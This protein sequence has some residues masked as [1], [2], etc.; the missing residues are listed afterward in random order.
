M[1]PSS[2][3]GHA[4]AGSRRVGHSLVTSSVPISHARG[5][6]APSHADSGGWVAAADG[7][8]WLD[9]G[10]LEGAFSVQLPVRSPAA[11]GGAATPCSPRW[12]STGPLAGGPRKRRLSGDASRRRRTHG[13]SVV[14]GRAA[15]RHQSDRPSAQWFSSPS[16]P[17]SQWSPYRSMTCP[18]VAP[19]GR[20]CKSSTI[21]PPL[22]EPGEP[23]AQDGG[24][25]VPSRESIIP[26]F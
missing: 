11:G 4:P 2:P 15:C 1:A 6:G 22:G 20:V 7:R 23:G 12:I 10:R 26:R 25:D 5:L 21:R 18:S 24:V 13:Q 16:N 9:P 17:I 3:T 14:I 19:Q 8:I